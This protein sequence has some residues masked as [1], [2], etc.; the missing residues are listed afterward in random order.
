VA[1]LAA[2]QER[3]QQQQQGRAQWVDAQRRQRTPVSQLSR[4]A[5]LASEQ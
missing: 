3:Q 2:V 4:R 1:E 5:E